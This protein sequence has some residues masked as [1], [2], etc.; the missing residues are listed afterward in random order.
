MF[1]LAVGGN[2]TYSLSIY[3]GD[4]NPSDNLPY[5]VGSTGTMLFDF[6]VFGQFW[7][8]QSGGGEEYEKIPDGK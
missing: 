2:L 7:A 4:G 6:V 1:A 5:L 3:L 8:Y